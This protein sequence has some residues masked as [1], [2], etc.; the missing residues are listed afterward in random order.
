M[1]EL[2]LPGASETPIAS[3]MSHGLQTIDS[4][5]RLRD[6]S[7]WMRLVGHE[8][9]PVAH[10]GQ[11]VGLLTRRD[12]DRAAEHGL[13]D[14]RARD[15][16]QPGTV[17]VGLTETVATLI[18]RMVETGWWQIPV[19]ND[20]GFPIGIVTRT[21]VLKFWAERSV[22]HQPT[23]VN[24]AQIEA[25]LGRAT[26]SLIG[27]IAD[28]ADTMN[29]RAYLVG[30]VVRDLLLHRANFD[31]DFVVEGQLLGVS[32]RELSEALAREYGGSAHHH[33]PFG[34]S[35]WRIDHASP[36]LQRAGVGVDSLPDHIDLVSSRHEYYE[37][38]TALPTVYSSSIKLDL[39]RRDFTINTMAIQVS[40]SADRGHL[41]DEFGGR[42]DLQNRLIRVLHSMSFVDDP[43]RI[44]RAVRYASR[45][46]FAIEPRTSALIDVAIQQK[47][48][49]QITGERLRNELSLLL[50]E[51]EPEIGLIE[52]ADRGALAA[53]HPA[54]QLSEALPTHLAEVRSLAY[55]HALGLET[56]LP[57]AALIWHLIGAEIEPLQLASWC[58]RLLIGKS[59]AESIAT[60]S[61]VARS[62]SFRDPDLRPSAAV[63]ELQGTSL[64]AQAALWILRPAVRDFVTQYVNVWQHV[65][66]ITT[67]ET[68]QAIGLKPGPCYGVILSRLRD[69]RVDR[70]VTTA[71]DELALAR[72]LI[73]QGVCS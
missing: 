5:A 30:G 63:R 2:L 67:G 31:I 16:M 12:A 6:I 18:R 58:D 71:E 17:T 8:G 39:Q 4:E 72:E 34:T 24:M 19:V 9:F 45:L 50:E 54:F 42:K 52:L 59:T 55:Q 69:A 27:L 22:Q 51:D 23:L 49:A 3:L 28:L 29:V 25:T 65:H 26:A 73:D 36:L 70:I 64:V 13:L 15:I 41:L 56:G 38:P 48:L 57:V 11:I 14:L 37:T 7:G 53:I 66:P 32:A 68:L 47:M 33:A 46:D 21:D 10:D 44:L 40:P 20:A 62:N 60:V 1:S 35:T 61:R 43:T